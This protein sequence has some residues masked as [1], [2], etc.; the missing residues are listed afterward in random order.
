MIR[1]QLIIPALLAVCI[2][3]GMSCSD[4]DTVVSIESME[5][6]NAVTSNVSFSF[7]GMVNGASEGIHIF[8]VDG[9]G[10]VLAMVHAVSSEHL[11]SLFSPY[12]IDVLK[13]DGI[14]EIFDEA[15]VVN[16]VAAFNEPG[17]HYDSVN[18]IGVVSSF[19]ECMAECIGEDPNWGK[20]KMC[21]YKCSQEYDP[22]QD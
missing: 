20:I 13:S 3:A 12:H 6:L 5:G 2:I 16:I 15:T 7:Q 9:D 10:S 8:F 1:L 21:Y 18:M 19:D 14:L 11:I 22:K 4:T 17:S